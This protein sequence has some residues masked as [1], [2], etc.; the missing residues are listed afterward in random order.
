MEG[1]VEFDSSPFKM[2]KMKG[3]DNMITKMKSK[4]SKSDRLQ[5][6]LYEKLLI[7][8][9]EKLRRGDSV[10]LNQ[11]LEQIPDKKLRDEFTLD[12]CTAGVIDSSYA[13]ET[14]SILQEANAKFCDISGK[15]TEN[16]TRRD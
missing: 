16:R 14:R 10:D 9:C 11:F 7:E 1:N 3:N 12:V 15:A 4:R 6:K 8:C 13:L 2:W 5:R